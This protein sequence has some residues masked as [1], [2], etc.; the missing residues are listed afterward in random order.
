MEMCRKVPINACPKCGHKQFIVRDVS[1]NTL[2]T[3]RE[4][5]IHDLLSEEKT[6]VGLCLNCNAIFELYPAYDSYIPLTPIRKFL[7]EYQPIYLD[8]TNNIDRTYID[9][10]MADNNKY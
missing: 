10:P 8:K 6:A 2:A 4:G 5:K 9:N 1:I 3:D 7:R